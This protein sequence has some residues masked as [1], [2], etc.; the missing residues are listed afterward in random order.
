[1]KRHQ[2][3]VVGA[4]AAGLVVAFGAASAGIDV[5]LI[6]AERLGGECTWTG[7]VPSK[8]L[9]DAARRAHEAKSSGHI[10]ISASDVTVDFP[11]LMGHI[12]GTSAHVAEEEGLERARRA[13]ITVYQ[14]FARFEDP[15]TLILDSGEQ[16]RAKRIVLATGGRPRVPPPLRSVRHL[17]SE[18][19]WDLAELPEHLA[20]VGG[21]AAGT[22]L[23]QAFRRLGSRV[24]I[25]TDVDRLLPAAHPDASRSISEQL[26]IEGITTHTNTNVVSAVEGDDELRL[27]I[28]DGTVVTASHVLVTIGRD[29]ALG[30]MN[31][32]SAG[33]ELDES[34]AP[35]LDDRLRT[36][37][38]HIYVCGDATGAGLTHIAS[39]QGAAVLLNIVSPRTFAADTGVPRWAIFTDPEIAQVGLTKDEAMGRGLDIRVTRI[40]ISRVD[41]ASVV[42]ASNGFLEA[43]HSRTGKLWGVTIVGPQAAEWANQWIEPVTKNRRVAELA[44]VPTIYPTMGSSNAV[45]AYEWGEA[46]LGRGLLGRVVR[47]VGRLRMRVARYR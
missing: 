35:V 34:G 27:A 15:H 4:G 33:I 16:I 17:T 42:G 6:E 19:I 1:M 26:R 25:I 9:I 12:H 10:G 46:M 43:V 5:A 40:P 8:T 45:V 30:S 18:T 22:E 7:C 21:G 38:G 2:I 20:V 47:I 11:A 36:N 14:S 37:L 23:A 29:V 44:F 41:R 24:T 28:E 32:E 31:P 39:S 13:G 3:A